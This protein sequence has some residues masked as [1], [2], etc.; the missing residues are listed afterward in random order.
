MIA[1]LL[2]GRKGSV[3]FPGKNLYPI[4]GHPMMLYPLSAAL[5]S[6]HIDETFVSTDDDKIKKISRNHGANII[7]RPAELCTSKAL[8]QDVLIHGYHWIRD[9]VTADIEFIVLLMC[10]AATITPQLIDTGIEVL[11]KNPTYDSAVS[12][13]RYNM[14]SPLRA[15]RLDKEGLLKPFV[16]FEALGDPSKLSD[17]RD[18]QGDVYFADMG[19]SIVR[20]RNLDNIK[21]G[22]LPQRWMGQRIYPLKQEGGFD[23]DYDWQMPAVEYWLKK[24]KVKVAKKINRK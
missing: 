21:E 20:T 16:P 11:R 5:N 12:V 22:L 17:S 3:G 1:A 7:D 6:K 15:R 19:V 8:G 10:N 13:S 14:W 2:I 23:V 9:N 24:N 18:S 4:A